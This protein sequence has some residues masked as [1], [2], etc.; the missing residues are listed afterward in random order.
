MASTSAHTHTLVAA[1]QR[2][3][4]RLWALAWLVL[5]TALLAA[6][7]DLLRPEARQVVRLGWA[8]LLLAAGLWQ[9]ARGLARGTPNAPPTFAM[10]RGDFAR[11]E[12]WVEAGAAD[13]SVSAFA[14]ASQLAVGDFP[15]AG[16]PALEARGETARVRLRVRDTLALWPGRGWSAAL[17]KGLP[18]ALDLRSSLGDLTL[19]LKDLDVTA[20]RVQSTLGHV[21]LTLPAAGQAEMRVRLRGGDLTVRVPEGMALRV[22]VSAGPLARVRPDARRFV[23]LAPGEWATPLYAASATRCTLALDLWAGDLTL[24]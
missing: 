14:G 11:G 17:A 7:L 4:Q 12:L 10:A 6:N 9:L 18:W 20:L 24:V 13:V 16:G 23:Q 2:R 8:G 22:K 19:N 15:A 3:R 21:D 5:G 1:R